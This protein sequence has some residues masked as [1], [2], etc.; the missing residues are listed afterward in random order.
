[1]RHW[2]V[3]PA[4]ITFKSVD[5][6]P[7]VPADPA[8]PLLTTTVTPALIAAALTALEVAV[9]GRR[10]ALARSELVGVHGQAHRA[11]G[12]PPLEA[13]RTEHLVEALRLGLVLHPVRPGD[14]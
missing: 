3:A 9:G 13:G 2:L 11:A 6:L 12:L 8:S 10:A 7:R 5:G 1:M 4:A 14:D